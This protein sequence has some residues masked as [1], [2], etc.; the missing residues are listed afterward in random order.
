MA[1][2]IMPMAAAI[3]VTLQ[4]GLL[5]RRNELTAMRAAGVGDHQILAAIAAAGFVL[6]VLHH[7]LAEFAAPPASRYAADFWRNE[8]QPRPEPA[9]VTLVVPGVACLARRAD[10][11]YRTLQDVTFVLSNTRN[12]LTRQ[13]RAEEAVFSGGAWQLRP[14]REIAWEGEGTRTET[15]HDHLELPLRLW[16]ED[17]ALR[18][19]KTEELS[20][21]SL[22]EAYRRDRDRAEEGRAWLVDW[23]GR[24]ATLAGTWVLSVAAAV[25]ALRRGYG[26]LVGTVGLGVFWT[27]AYWTFTNTFLALGYDGC[28]PPVVAAWLPNALMVVASLVLGLGGARAAPR[29]QPAKA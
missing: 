15:T 10:P 18:H 19:R 25:V 17:F 11:S 12:R 9:D 16:P 2:R 24:L 13:V 4:L 7:G 21:R 8:V 14:C 3:A 28:L 6:M 27:F 1:A 29:R 5:S 20:L 23:H 26:D 22:T